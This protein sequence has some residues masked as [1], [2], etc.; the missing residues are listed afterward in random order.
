MSDGYTDSRQGNP[1]YDENCQSTER[2][3]EGYNNVLDLRSTRPHDA[4]RHKYLKGCDELYTSNIHKDKSDELTSNKDHHN[5]NR[6]NEIENDDLICDSPTQN[7]TKIVEESVSMDKKQSIEEHRISLLEKHYDKLDS[8]V[9][10]SIREMTKGFADLRVDMAEHRA[11]MNEKL[12]SIRVD[13]ATFKTEVNEKLD[14]IRVDNANFKTE[15]IEKLDDQK[16]WIIWIAIS[17][18]GIALSG[19]GIAIKFLS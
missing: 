3:N 17:G 11:N 6:D 16:Q 19:I 9:D 2:S 4:N 14:G 1:S 10:S 5:T 18:I 8:K 12:D 7:E 15:V 13:N